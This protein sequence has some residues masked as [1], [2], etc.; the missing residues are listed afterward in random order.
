VLRWGAAA[1]V[2]VAAHAGAVWVAV[3]WSPAAVVANDPPPAVTIDLAPLAVAPPAPPDEVAPGPQ[4]TESLPEPTPD[5]V[6]PVEDAIPNPAP[7]E[8]MDEA[9]LVAAPPPPQPEPKVPEL[10]KQEDAEAV[11]QPPVPQ[12]RPKHQPSAKH[13]AGRKRPVHRDR[14]EVRRIT[15][16]PR[17]E[18]RRAETA[19]AP[20]SGQ[21]RVPSVSP[22]AWKTA[23]MARLN[24]YKRYP[25]DAS[26]SGTASVAFTIDRAGTVLASRL[27][28]SSG[29]LALDRE[30][31]SLP[32][33]ASPVPAPP[34]DLG[35]GRSITLTVPVRFDR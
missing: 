5:V 29:D 28:G 16:P 8:P 30:A 25:A 26:G 2:V 19:A 31:R 24:R 27:I 4:V 32:R 22:A 7:P 33:R 17:I 21:S 9:R 23:L 13:K 6:N 20:V 1:A 12:P 14:R 3:E 35:H 15:V 18:G 34:A 10:P 11:L